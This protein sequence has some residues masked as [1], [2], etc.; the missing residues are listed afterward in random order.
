[1][2]AWIT[3]WS[4]NSTKN[5]CI[6]I[7]AFCNSVWPYFPQNYAHYPLFN[8]GSIKMIHYREKH[9]GMDSCLL[10]DQFSRFC[11]LFFLFIFLCHFV[12]ISKFWAE[13]SRQMN[14]F[15]EDN[16]IYFNSFGMIICTE[17]SHRHGVAQIACSEIGIA[18]L[19]SMSFCNL[20]GWLGTSKKKA[21]KI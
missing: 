16:G 6:S 20:L 12:K 4:G 18:S 21:T 1:M 19:L 2:S 8:I 11:F 10:Y 5:T 7:R 14:I 9:K 13:I 3:L 15:L 17:S